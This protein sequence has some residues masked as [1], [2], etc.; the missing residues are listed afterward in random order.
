MAEVTHLYRH[1]EI[2]IQ[3]PYACDVDASDWLRQGTTRDRLLGHNLRISELRVVEIAEMEG[4][5]VF[6]A[7]AWQDK[8][9]LILGDCE[10]Y[11]VLDPANGATK[12]YQ[13][14]GEKA[15]CWYSCKLP[16]GKLLVFDRRA[17]HLQN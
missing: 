11:L 6:S 12:R 2:I 4:N 10:I 13:F 9:F 1:D 5:V 16:S 3:R 15:L 7:F 8:V 17:G 14:P